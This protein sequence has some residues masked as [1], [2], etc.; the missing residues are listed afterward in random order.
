VRPN[1]SIENP[2]AWITTVTARVCLDELRARRRRNEAPLLA[3]AI[4]AAELAADEAILE[5]EFL[6][7][8]ERQRE[9]VVQPHAVSNDLAR[10]PRALV[11]R[12]HGLQEQT[13]PETTDS[14]TISRSPTAKLTVPSVEE[15]PGRARG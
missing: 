7:L 11:R 5:H 14:K 6:D 10:I 9:T 3:D 8:P 12:R 2:S 13:L 4:P 1:P 15:T